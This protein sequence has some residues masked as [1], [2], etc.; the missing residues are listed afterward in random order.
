[1]NDQVNIIDACTGVTMKVSALAKL[2]AELN[3]PE[4]I[5]VVPTG[6]AWDLPPAPDSDNVL[7]V[8]HLQGARMVHEWCAQIES[9]ETGHHMRRPCT[10]STHS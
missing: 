8:K 9:H 10:A 4:S 7:S 2:T 3:Y 6:D 5:V 1:M